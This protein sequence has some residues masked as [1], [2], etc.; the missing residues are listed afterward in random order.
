MTKEDKIIAIAKW[1]GFHQIKKV[2]TDV[3]LETPIGLPPNEDFDYFAPY[4]EDGNYCYIPK[5]LEDLN[6]VNRLVSRLNKKALAVYGDCLNEIIDAFYGDYYDG[7]GA[8]YTHGSFAAA[9]AAISQATAEQK[10]DALIQALG[11]KSS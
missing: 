2:W 5:Y 9:I 11:L 8:N 4:E 6:I 7:W 10:C 3:A 1:H